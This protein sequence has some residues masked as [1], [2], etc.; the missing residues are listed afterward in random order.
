MHLEGL[1]SI[2]FFGAQDKA[3]LGSHTSH[4]EVGRQPVFTGFPRLS[5]YSGQPTPDSHHVSKSPTFPTEAQE[6]ASLCHEL[7][8]GLFLSHT[9]FEK[10]LFEVLVNDCGEKYETGR[11]KKTLKEISI[12]NRTLHNIYRLDYFE[13]LLGN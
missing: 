6:A 8:P 13:K 10:H 9:D 1:C 3:W 11:R 5:S 12:T 7:N 4:G 2:H